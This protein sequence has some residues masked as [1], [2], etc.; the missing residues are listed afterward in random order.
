MNLTAR[1]QSKSQSPKT[2]S[3]AAT[4]KS[5]KSNSPRQSNANRKKSSEI[6]D[7]KAKRVRTGCLTCRERHLKCDEALGRCLNCRKS[8]RICRRGIRLNFI[9]IQTHAPPHVIARPR[10]AKVTFRDDSRF[11]ASEYVG[12]FERYPP[13]QPESPVQERRQL[14]HE[15]FNLM[16]HDQLASL[17]Q[18]VAHSFDPSAF[19][20]SHSVADLLGG[21]DTWHDSHLMPGDELLPHGASRFARKLAMKQYNPSSLT[22]PEQVYL[23]QVF[24][25]EVGLWMDSMDATRHVRS[26]ISLP[27]L[28]FPSHHEKFTQILPLHAIDEPMLLKAFLACGARHLSLV[29]PSYGTE[30][31]TS[32]Y[33]MATQDLMN[34]IQDPN[35]DSVLCTTAALVLSVYEV[36]APQPALESNHISGSRA[37]LR[38]CGWTAKTS[39]LG[40]TCFWVSVIMEL[41]SSLHFKWSLSWN[42]DSWGVDMNMDHAQP[43][44]KGDDLWVH[45][46]IYICAK[47][48]NFRIAMEHLQSLGDSA[49]QAQINDALQEWNL[50]Q[51]WCEQWAKTAPRSVKPLGHVHPWQADSKS[52]FPSIWLL[53]RPAIVSQLFYHTACIL[54]AKAHPMRSR[55]GL[56]M[57]E[58]QQIHAHDICGIATN[59][60]DKGV[61]NVLIRC[62]AIAAEC[63]ETRETQNEALGIFDTIVKDSIWHAEPIQDELKHVWGWQV[64]HPETVDPTQ[65]HHDYYGLDPALR[66]HNGPEFP[67]RVSNPLLTASDF[68]LD[69]HPYQGFYVAPHHHTLQ[70]YHY[71]PYLI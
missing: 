32:Y 18:S 23:L 12:G 6:A 48:M 7:T 37:L 46:S 16:G 68:S 21:P 54:L 38:E 55:I 49:S 1:R 36:I 71:E 30:K 64:A 15:A 25:E 8:D 43:F 53:K 63:L 34:A 35:R 3:K 26:R 59:N 5:Q 28:S 61:V 9:D 65:M 19:E 70:N 31:A 41:L 11:I 58:L 22:D 66:I 42:P 2:D 56:E 52:A 10:G 69:N 27:V 62:L 20:F 4:P 17:F 60:K 45:R 13:P 57:K 47:I 39:G 24:V 29:N 14:H 33:D 44:G 67:P 50:Y 51:S 40:G